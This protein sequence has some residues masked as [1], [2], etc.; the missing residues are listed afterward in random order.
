[1]GLWILWLW[2]GFVGD[3]VSFG[4]DIFNDD[5]D[6]YFVVVGMVDGVYF[7]GFFDEIFFYILSY[8][9]SIDLILN[10]WCICWKFVVLCFDKSFIYIVLL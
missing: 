1:M 5:D 6:M 7:L 8:V 3:M 4:E 9:F 2:F 10:V